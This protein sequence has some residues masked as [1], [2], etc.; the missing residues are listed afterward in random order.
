[1]DDYINCIVVGDPHFQVNN[2]NECDE[3]IIKLNKLIEKIQPTF[4]VIL[5]DLLHTHERIH[6]DPLNKAIKLLISLSLKIEVFLLI[7]NHDYC[8]NQQ[9]LTKNHPFNSLKKIE[10]IIICDRVITREYNNKKFIFC[11]YVP[12]KRFEEALNTLKEKGREW[13]DA[14]CIFAHQEFYGCK[15]NPVSTSTEGDVWSK[16]NPLVISGHI[17]EKQ[18]LQDNIYYPG[19]SMQHSFGESA[20]KTI[21][22]ITFK[23]DSK[24]SIDCIDLE[25][26]KKKIIYLNIED[27]DKFVY[28]PEVNIKLV[29]KGY[30]EE[31]VIFRKTKKYNEL[32]KKGLKISFLPKEKEAIVIEREQ[33]KNVMVILKKLINKEDKYVHKAYEE[34]LLHL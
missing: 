21:A 6:V 16:S 14:N 34:L 10:N 24:I 19:S 5:G 20:D 15:Y 13:K 1:M 32:V 17:H 31:I 11:P 26:K 23:E 27:I 4:I 33:K 22:L 9:F 28:D 25:M 8:N 7:G 2:I 30:S 3:L 18:R 12:P 29:I